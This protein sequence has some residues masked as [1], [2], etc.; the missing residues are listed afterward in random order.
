MQRIERI[1]RM[2]PLNG[3]NGVHVP[4]LHL[5]R[6]LFLG[7]SRNT[8]ID[9]E[10]A[11]AHEILQGRISTEFWEQSERAGKGGLFLAEPALQD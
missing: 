5:L 3:Q 4:L 6:L 7:S 11:T 8:G 2:K 1:L 10:T 9:P